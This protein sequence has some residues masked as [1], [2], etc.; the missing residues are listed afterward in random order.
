MR[1]RR[2]L[3]LVYPQERR[4]GLDLH[5][6]FFIHGAWL[7][8]RPGA[9]G[10]HFVQERIF[11]APHLPFSVLPRLQ[12]QQLGVRLSPL[13]READISQQAAQLGLAD[14]EPRIATLRFLSHLTTPRRTDRCRTFGVL[15]L[16][17]GPAATGRWTDPCLGG[18]CLLENRMS[19]LVDYGRLRYRRNPAA[20]AQ[21]Q[22]DPN[23]TCG[24]LQ[25]PGDQD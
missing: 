21:I 25:Y 1:R 13:Q 24:Y 11:L 20:P 7:C 19:L 8:D 23:E 5:L 3:T 2:F 14:A 6:R 9:A 12:V 16:L 15:V 10:T 4:S 22:I 18:N 17:P